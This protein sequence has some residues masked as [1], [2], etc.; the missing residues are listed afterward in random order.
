MLGMANAGAVYW[1]SETQGDCASRYHLYCF[2]SDLGETIMVPP[3]IPGKRLFVTTTFWTPTDGRTQ[4]DTLCQKEATA[5]NLSG[6]FIAFL[7]TTDSAAIDK[8]QPGRWKRTD[9]VLVANTI[10]DFVSDGLMASVGLS[11]NQGTHITG[12]IWSGAPSASSRASLES[13]CQDFK[14]SAATNIGYAGRSYTT[15][16]LEW[17]GNQKLACNANVWLLCLEP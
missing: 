7:S 9:N 11:A 1:T 14:S 4:A 6:T 5:A 12:A 2:R 8:L 10:N 17:F 16:P 15:D 13:S 3:A